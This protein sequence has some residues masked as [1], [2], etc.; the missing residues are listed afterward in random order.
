MKILKG[1]QGLSTT[2]IYLYSLVAVRDCDKHVP[3]PS[4]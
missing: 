2:V 1:G 3:A 4:I